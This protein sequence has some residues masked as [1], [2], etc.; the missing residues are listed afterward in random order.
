MC[1]DLPTAQSCGSNTYATFYQ[2]AGVDC[3]TLTGTDATFNKMGD[4]DNKY[5]Q[6]TYPNS[7]KCQIDA[8]VQYNL[9]VNF[10][11]DNNQDFSAEAAATANMCSP[12]IN[13][14]SRYA[15]EQGQINAFW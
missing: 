12:V 15:C 13:V 14:K 6:L 5:I 11:C 9:V 7:P 2:A 1:Q 8:S 10:Y 4:D 3:Q